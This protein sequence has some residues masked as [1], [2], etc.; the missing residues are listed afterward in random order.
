MKAKMIAAMAASLIAGAAMADGIGVTWVGSSGMAKRVLSGFSERMAEAAPDWTIEVNGELADTDALAASFESYAATYGHVVVLRSNGSKWLAGNPPSVP[1]FIGGENHPPSL[2]VIENMAAP[3]GNITGV[4]YYLDPIVVLETLTAIVPA[5]KVLFIQ[6]EGHPGSDVDKAGFSLAC[7]DL[8]LECAFVR[9][10]DSAGL[11]DTIKANEGYGAIVIGNQVPLFDDADNFA[12]G[13]EAA[14]DVPILGLH[15]QVAALG[16]LAALAANDRKLG[17]ML[18][19]TVLNVVR[20]GQAIAD[21][22]VG[23]DT[24]PTL[25]LNE[26]TLNTLGLSVPR[27]MMDVAEV[28]N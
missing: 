13:V 15:K 27:Q 26:A 24:K 21:T 18:A 7:D 5:E 4:T 6:Q 12:A 11:A 23:T 22:P 20:D 19:D 28:V 3:E 1:T 16:G 9:I 8:F 10:P 14:G 25:F 17:A 2:G